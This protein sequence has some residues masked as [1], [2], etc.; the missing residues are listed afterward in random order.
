[1]E[2]STNLWVEIG[3]QCLALARSLMAH[4]PVS[5]EN[6][7][8]ACELVQTAVAIDRLNLDWMKTQSPFSG[9]P[10]R[11]SERLTGEN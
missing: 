5:T 4:D 11:P 9:I 6:L 7:H 3:D 8:I 2:K 10:A 1:M